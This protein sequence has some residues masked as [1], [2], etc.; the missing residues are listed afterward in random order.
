MEARRLAKLLGQHGPD[1]GGRSVYHYHEWHLRVRMA[2]DGGRAE[3]FLELF[4]GFV[5]IGVP[6]QGL[7]LSLQEGG[8]RSSEHTVVLDESTIEVGKSQ[9][10]LQVLYSLW[11][12][13]YGLYFPLVHLDSI[14]ADDVPEEL[15]RGVMELTFLQLE[16]EVMLSEPLEDL[17]HMV[18]MFG[19]VPGVYEDVVDV[20]YDETMEEL[21][22]R[23]QYLPI[24]SPMPI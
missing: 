7:G 16:V 14:L 23:K 10:L 18:A 21:N 8:E 2:Q 6:G 19:Q 17:L 3:R 15:H 24:R 5:G 22:H 9:E 4:N 11:D 12:F 1:S 13:P 20:H